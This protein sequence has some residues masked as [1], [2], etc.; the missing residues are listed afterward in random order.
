MTSNRGE[1][2]YYIIETH[3]KDCYKN[4]EYRFRSLFN[5]CVGSWKYLRCEAVEQGEA[6]AKIIERYFN[7]CANTA[8]TIVGRM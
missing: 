6:H 3:C 5:G 1:G 4:F 8:P 2:E 7:A